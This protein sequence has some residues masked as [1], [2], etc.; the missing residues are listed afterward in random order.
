MLLSG[1]TLYRVPMNLDGVTTLPELLGTHGYATFGTGKWHNGGVSFLRSFQR[2]K[3]VMLGG[4]SDHTLVPVRDVTEA[5][6]FTEPR[7]GPRFSSELFADAIIEFL[8]GHDGERPFFAYAAFTAPHDPRQPPERLRKAYYDDPPPLPK[9]FMPQHPFHNGWMVGRDEQLAGWPR[10]ETVIRDQLAEYYGMITHLDEQIGRVLEALE[11]SGH[12]EDTIVVYAA[13]HGLA[14]GSHGL[15][16]K[17]NVYE[18]SMGC[19]LLFGGPGIPHGESSAL[20]YLLDVFPTLCELTG[21]APPPGVEGKSLVGVW[22]GDHA[23]VRD[24]LFLTYENKMRAVRDARYKLIRYPLIDHIQLFDLEHDPDELHDLAVVP[25]HSGRVAQMMGLLRQWQ[26]QVDDPHPL[27][28]DEPLPMEI[29]LTG[30]KRKP[31]HWQP[32]WIIEKYFSGG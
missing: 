16:G 29:D 22:R 18:H 15:L 27:H 13:D 31:D 11:R 7:T 4:M 26:E 3:A 21:V 17:Q 30:R 5:G 32:D 25:A 6:E 10:T 14:L 8:D 24:T 28:I 19:P 9:N 12:G 23:S 2:G 20:T 1:R